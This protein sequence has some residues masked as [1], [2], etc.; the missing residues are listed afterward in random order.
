MNGRPVTLRGRIDKNHEG[1]DVEASLTPYPAR[2]RFFR[3]MGRRWIAAMLVVYGLG[4]SAWVAVRLDAALP[5]DASMMGTRKDGV[6]HALRTLQDGGPPLLA[7]AGGYARETARTTCKPAGWTDDQGLYLYLPYFA[8]WMGISD[9]SRAMKML[10]VGSFSALIA[11][12]PLIWWGVFD[13]LLAGGVL[14]L[15]LVFKWAFVVNPDIYWV[16]A[17][18]LLLGLPLLFLIHHRWRARSPLALVGVVVVGSLAS[19]IRSH[20]GLPIFLGAV[21]I[22]ILRRS[23]WG[24]TLSWAA[25]LVVAYLCVHPVGFQAVRM[26]RDHVVGDPSW[27]A[28]FPARHPV[29]HSMYIGL[30]HL[31]N[32]YGIVWDDSFAVT[33]VARLNPRAAYVSAE[34]ERTLRD[35]YFRIA[36][37]DPWFVIG[38]LTSKSKATAEAAATRFGGLLLLIPVALLAGS[39]KRTMRR[40]VLVVAV[41]LP[42]EAA[43]PLLTLPILEY[44]MSWVAAWAVLWLL[45]GGWLLTT[46]PGDIRRRLETVQIPIPEPRTPS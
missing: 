27:S 22:L 40:Y 2:E 46:V 19:S 16:G 12:Y 45:A 41:G 1:R 37:E 18:Y 10:F 9:P 13:S 26:Y 3:H 35:E 42:I 29:W 30:S 5:A 32:R 33:T 11:L 15:A 28:R 6:Q 21:V 44:Q 14:P 31:P 17:W 43:A 36:R 25:T 24:R 39:A 23:S 4:L 38:N 20:A 34:Y 7:C 8:H